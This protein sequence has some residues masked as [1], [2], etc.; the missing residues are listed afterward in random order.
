MAAKKFK[1]SFAARDGML[2]G[3]DILASAV[4]VILGPK[5]RNAA[6]DTSYSAPRK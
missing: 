3:I 4:G 6:I 5:G 2:R 1:F